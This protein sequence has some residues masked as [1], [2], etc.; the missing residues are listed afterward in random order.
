MSSKTLQNYCLRVKPQ[1]I[2][3]VKTWKAFQ[4]LYNGLFNNTKSNSNRHKDLQIT[5]F[6]V[7]IS[8]QCLVQSLAAQERY[9]VKV[10]QHLQSK[11]KET[12]YRAL[13]SPWLLGQRTH[14]YL[15][16]IKCKVKCNKGKQICLLDLVKFKVLWISKDSNL[17]ATYR[18]H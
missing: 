5:L 3:S 13:Y 1:V 16:L 4:K 2:K 7:V 6:L 8:I 18:A 11:F 10:F 14:F 17:K 15:I 9:M 12:K